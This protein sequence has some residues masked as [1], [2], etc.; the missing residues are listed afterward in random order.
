[1]VRNPT[2]PARGQRTA[3][4]CAIVNPVDY[5]WCVEPHITSQQV[6]ATAGATYRQLDHWVRTGLLHP[7]IPANGSGTQRRWSLDDAVRAAAIAKLRRAGVTLARAA[8]I[9]DGAP[10]D[11]PVAVTLDLD[12]IRADVEQQLDLVPA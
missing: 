5:A 8:A 11:P 4:A 12:V 7:Q 3:T 10:V 9:L 6:A 2:R 1:M